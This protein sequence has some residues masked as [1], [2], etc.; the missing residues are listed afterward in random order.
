M[1]NTKLPAVAYLSLALC[2]FPAAAELPLPCK[3]L[4]ELNESVMSC[5]DNGLVG[6]AGV[7]CVQ[8]LEKLIQSRANEAVKQLAASHDLHVVQKGN[9]QAHDFAGTGA[10][11]GISEAA[12]NEL[13]TAA[14]RARS[15]VDGYLHNIVFPDYFNHSH[16]AIGD[17]FEFMD[18]S[19]CYSENRDGL[20]QLI[21][22][23]DKNIA[24]LERTR[25]G[26]LA[27][28]SAASGREGMQGSLTVSATGGRAAA[29]SV[30]PVPSAQ[31]RRPASDIT[32]VKEDEKKRLRAP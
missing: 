22:R 31:N 19:K 29:G 6:Q 10:G 1:K 9:N 18:N 23:V 17:P 26:S 32:G 2:S 15:N 24:D 13:I 21:K 16:A 11:Y 30:A 5:N 27:R 8:A 20:R 4:E 7:A 28:G 14:K 12:L 3:G 25:Q